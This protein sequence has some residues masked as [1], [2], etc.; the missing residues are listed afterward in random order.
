MPRAR[1]NPNP[2]RP[3]WIKSVYHPLPDNVVSG[4]TDDLTTT[5]VAF[6]DFFDD[7]TAES[8]QNTASSSQSLTAESSSDTGTSTGTG[9]QNF[10]LD[11][12]AEGFTNSASSS[13]SMDESIVLLTGETDDLTTS[14]SSTQVLSEAASESDDQSGSGSQSTA[15]ATAESPQNSAA[16]SQSTLDASS[17]AL[18]NSSS[19]SQSVLEASAEALTNSA[20]STQSLFEA[21]ADTPRNSATNTPNLDAVAEAEMPP[22]T[23]DSSQN[24]A[25]ATAESPQNT[26]T[27][28]PNLS[29]PAEAE[30][31][32]NVGDSSQSTADATA[33]SPQNSAASAQT[34]DE[35]IGFYVSDTL[36]VVGAATHAI[37]EIVNS[38][39]TLDTVGA[40]SQTLFDEVAAPGVNEG[41]N[42]QS[43]AE[44]T[45]EGVDNSGNSTQLTLDA[46]AESP[47]SSA[48]ASFTIDEVITIAPETVDQQ[49][50]S[51]QS[52]A[53]EIGGEVAPP[54]E[55]AVGQLGEGP[56]SFA[57][58][59]PPNRDAIDT[60]MH[61]NY[62]EQT[63]GEELRSDL[64]QQFVAPDPVADVLTS[65]AVASHDYQGWYEK[66]RT[67][68]IR[69]LV[70][71]DE[72]FEPLTLMRDTDEPDVIL[73][74][75]RAAKEQNR[76]V[77]NQLILNDLL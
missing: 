70:A 62:G 52:M 69:S 40:S 19:S 25:E 54:Q 65:V 23:G 2:K 73:G 3:F 42:A 57:G 49:Q 4:E 20:A 14:Q 36:D 16:G 31:P 13:Q 6:Q 15:E 71:T 17:E 55:P 61:V 24:L 38:V 28:D 45:A 5:Q 10:S 7:A 22:N 67:D 37:D 43:L 32:P 39:D 60:I 27:N 63:I 56:H 8:P 30:M 66:G 77:Y 26:A 51:T 58:G 76:Q 46:T 74:M 44:A 41:T 59:L 72:G 21:E 68:Q 34:I 48:A 9:S 18:V 64:T 11:A 33:E 12:T 47:Q 53:E 29:A 75:E 1:L 35:I 50:T